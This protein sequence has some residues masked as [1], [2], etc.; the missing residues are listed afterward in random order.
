MLGSTS[1]PNTQLAYGCGDEQGLDFDFI[2][3]RPA[4]HIMPQANLSF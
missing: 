3:L 4:Q 1:T 2:T